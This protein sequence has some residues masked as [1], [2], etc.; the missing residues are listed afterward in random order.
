MKRVSMFGV[1]NGRELCLRAAHA[2]VPV[3]DQ[4]ISIHGRGRS[5]DVADALEAEYGIKVTG[6]HVVTPETGLYWFSPD[7]R[8]VV[9]QSTIQPDARFRIPRDPKMTWMRFEEF[10]FDLTNSGLYRIWGEL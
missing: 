4:F 3:T 10:I 9:L 8:G 5:N 2:G 6:E 7:I 1:T